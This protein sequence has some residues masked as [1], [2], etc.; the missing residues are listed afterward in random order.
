MTV[1]LTVLIAAAAY[2]AVRAQQHPLAAVQSAGPTPSPSFPLKPITSAV[3]SPVPPAAAA[4]YTYDVDVIDASIGWMLVS[5]CPLHNA[6]TCR[7]AVVATSDGG[8]TWSKPV[9]VGPT[10]ASGDG[11]APRTIRFLNHLDGFVYGSSGAF[12][13]HDAGGT[14]L[15]VSLPAVF[16]SSISVSAGVVWSVTYPCL[17]G[18]LCEYEVRSSRDAGRTW[19]PVHKLPL[20]FSPVE[21]VAFPSGL[22]LSSVPPGKIEI[23]SDSGRT[24]RDVTSPCTEAHF[25]SFVS[26]SDGTALWHVCMDYPAPSGVLSTGSLFVSSDGGTSWVERNIQRHLFGWLATPRPRVA[27][28]WSDNTMIVTHDGG[29]TWTQARPV[30][31]E[32]LHFRD[33]GWG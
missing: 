22:M 27:Y 18:T 19:S 8:Q 11:G 20:N 3:P 31:L 28:A 21:A 17:K 14:W 12:V 2:G 4:F 30:Q 9:Q 25:G 6:P 33:L 29:A 24:W 13:S 32:S 10:F 5:N 7:H 1:S 15:P 23:T 26:T 16:V